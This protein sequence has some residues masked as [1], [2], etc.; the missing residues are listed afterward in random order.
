[1]INAKPVAAP[2]AASI[3]DELCIT[4]RALNYKISGERGASD[5]DIR[6][7]AVALEGRGEHF[8][9]YVC[10]LR[11]VLARLFEHDCLKEAA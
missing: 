4:V 5:A 7:A 6:S 8:L 1:M 2:A 10:K 9:A 3:A 11:A